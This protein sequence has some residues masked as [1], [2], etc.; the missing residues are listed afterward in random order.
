M[1][2][3]SDSGL[4]DRPVGRF[5][6]DVKDHDGTIVATGGDES[7]A[8][9]VEVDAHDTGVG[10]EG[11][12]GPGGVLDGEAA[13]ET[14]S[15]LQELVATVGNGEHI[16]VAGVPAHGGNVLSLGLLSGEAPEGK[17]G[18]EGFG[19]GVVSVV[20]VVLVIVEDVV[21]S[22]LDDHALH[23]LEATL[24]GSGVDGLLVLDLDDLSGL[25]VLGLALGGLF[26]FHAEGILVE[27]HEGIEDHPLGGLLGEDRGL[28]RISLD[29]TLTVDND[30][31]LG[32]SLLVVEHVSERLLLLV[33]SI[34]Y[35]MMKNSN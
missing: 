26:G 34:V 8:G 30:R 31:G 29:T 24:H 35:Y 23:N 1:L 20:L 4:V 18:S 16:L 9:R 7:G 10:G 13:D 27:L 6:T 22:V 21:L 11:V 32:G 5:L 25:L 17:D 15:L 14:A 19:V 33:K 2:V 28:G 12:L 3:S